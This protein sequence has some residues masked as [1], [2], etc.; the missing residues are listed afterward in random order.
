MVAGKFTATTPTGTAIFDN[1]LIERKAALTP[2]DDFN[3]NS[4]DGARPS[5]R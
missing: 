3:D 1:L 5:G 4:L 2:G